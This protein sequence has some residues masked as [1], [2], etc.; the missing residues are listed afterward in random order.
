LRILQY[1]FKIKKEELNQHVISDSLNAVIERVEKAVRDKEDPLAAVL[2]GVDDPWEVCLLKMMAEVFGHSFPGHVREM[3]RHHLFDEPEN[4]AA[5]AIRE[6]IETHFQK[7]AQDAGHIAE[8][9]RI[10]QK[11][12]LFKEYED[13]FFAL[14]KNKK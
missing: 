3:E 13:R 7:A 8:L 4:N 14:L 10:L 9:G 11:S 1:G 6:D 12:G 5:R 2:V